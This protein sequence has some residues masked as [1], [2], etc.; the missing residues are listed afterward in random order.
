MFERIPKVRGAYLFP[1]VRGAYLVFTFS[2]LYF[3]NQMCV[4]YRVDI[5][6]GLSA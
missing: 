5:C 4:N 2:V 3:A 1:K 6:F